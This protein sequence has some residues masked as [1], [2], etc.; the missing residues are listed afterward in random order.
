MREPFAHTAVLRLQDDAD[1]SAPGAAI[2]VALCGHWE[3]EP[4][5]PLAPHHTAAEREGDEVHLRTLFLVET[6]REHEVRDRIR[7]ALEAGS[8]VG[9][10]GRESRW[11]LRRSEAAALG[12][13]EA[14]RARR[15]A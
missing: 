9:P 12:P 1:L 13:A 5:C 8:L 4:P 2:T 11:R 14:D 10:D 3:H 7:G 15:L 6:T